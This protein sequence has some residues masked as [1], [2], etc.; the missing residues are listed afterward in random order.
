M[1]DKLCESIPILPYVHLPARHPQVYVPSVLV[2]V[3]TDLQ[4]ISGRNVHFEIV[5]QVM[6]DV[7]G[8]R[9]ILE[10]AVSAGLGHV[11]RQLIVELP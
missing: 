9:I 3:V 7:A 5:T 11:A 8:Q 2:E 1:A 10:C 4:G 6:D